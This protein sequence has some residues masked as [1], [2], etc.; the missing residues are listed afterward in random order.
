MKKLLIIAALA[1]FVAGGAFAQAKPA[2]APD[3]AL[4]ACRAGLD[5]EYKA[6]TKDHAEGLKA[7]KMSKTEE[8]DYQKTLDALKT[9]WAEAMKDG[10]N[11]KECTDQRAAIKKA[12]TELNEMQAVN[13]KVHICFDEFKK[14][15]AESDK[16]IAD[17]V[18][19]KAV[20]AKEEAAYKKRDEALQK[21]YDAALKSGKVTQADCDSLLKS[22]KAEHAAA[23][24]MA[25]VKTASTGPAAAADPAVTACL[26]DLTKEYNALQA[27]AAKPDA[28]VTAA[29]KAEFA[30]LDNEL[31]RKWTAARADGKVSIAE[32]NTQRTEIKNVQVALDKMQASK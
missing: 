19:S 23:V 27:D 11:L 1:T 6:L 8:A 21:Q 29:E 2:A 10:A 28:N 22:A 9:K 24:K 7:K 31:K 12:N 4:K 17:G 13:G 3:P 16:I 26:A 20:D 30:K 5:T 14:V 32:C 25:A 15:S 18:K